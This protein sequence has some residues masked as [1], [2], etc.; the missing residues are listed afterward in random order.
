M[1]GTTGGKKLT[2]ARHHGF[3]GRQLVLRF[4][5]GIAASGRKDKIGVQLRQTLGA[6]VNT[7]TVR[8]AVDKRREGESGITQHA[9]QRMIAVHGG[10]FA[11]VGLNDR[12][13]DLLGVYRR[14]QCVKLFLIATFQNAQSRLRAGQLRQLA[15]DL[16]RA[17]VEMID[18]HRGSDP[19]QLLNRRVTRRLGDNQIRFCG[20]NGF[21]IDIRCAD[22]FDV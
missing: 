22:K 6:H 12:N 4:A 11:L 20:G 14:F 1:P 17:A 7:A 19:R 5:T 18:A 2:P 10:D 15:V 9:P 8:D 16:R 21:N 13:G 3:H